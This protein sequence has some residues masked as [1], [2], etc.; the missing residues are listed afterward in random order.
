MFSAMKPGNS[1]TIIVRGRGSPRANTDVLIWERNGTVPS[2][3]EGAALSPKAAITGWYAEHPGEREQATH[4]RAIWMSS[5]SGSEINMSWTL[6]LLLESRPVM[7]MSDGS[8][9]R[10]VSGPALALLSG[11]GR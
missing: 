1:K 3:N 7:R 9:D 6:D 8:R 5:C 2:P 4:N 10:T 11:R